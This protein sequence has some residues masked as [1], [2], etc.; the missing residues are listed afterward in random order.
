M[1]ERRRLRRDLHDHVGH[2]LLKMIHAAPDNRSRELAEEAMKELANSIKNV[3][4]QSISVADF[5]KELQ[6][7]VEDFCRSADL[8]CTSC[9]GI[10][11]HSKT[12]SPITRQSLLSVVREVLNNAVRHSGASHIDSSILISDDGR[13]LNL[14]IK[15]NGHGFDTNLITPGDGLRNIQERISELGGVVQ[16]SCES[17]TEVNIQLQIS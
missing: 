8:G 17:G 14:T 2:K 4:I 15:D 1:D 5:A 6:T 13:D 9:N 3:Q 10:T 12:V 7:T 11:S 16:W